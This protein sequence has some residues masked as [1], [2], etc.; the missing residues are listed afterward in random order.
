MLAFFKNHTNPNNFY[1]NERDEKYSIFCQRLP[2]DN[3]LQFLGENNYKHFI[4]IVGSTI[5]AFSEKCNSPAEISG[6]WVKFSLTISLY[7]SITSL[8]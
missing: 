5:Y 6:N 3:T 2:F 1:L 8:P 4:E 7:Q